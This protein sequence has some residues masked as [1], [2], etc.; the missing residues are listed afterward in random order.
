MR[1][2][3]LSDEEYERLV[4]FVDV[5]FTIATMKMRSSRGNY[6]QGAQVKMLRLLLK[7]ITQRAEFKEGD[8]PELI[9]SE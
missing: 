8:P 4:G 9:D 2:L 3:T 6:S 7:A 5:Q 1:I